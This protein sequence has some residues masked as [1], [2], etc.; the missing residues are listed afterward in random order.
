MLE[1]DIERKVCAYAKDK[2]VITI[3]FLSVISGVPDRIFIYFDSVFFVEFKT[4]KGRFS[5]QQKIV[6]SKI[7]VKNVLIYIIRDIDTGKKADKFNSE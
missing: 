6:F 2:N 7:K 5:D 4:Q 3:K 1:R